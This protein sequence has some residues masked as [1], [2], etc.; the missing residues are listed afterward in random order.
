MKANISDESFFEPTL[1]PTNTKNRG[2]MYIDD[3]IYDQLNPSESMQ[4]FLEFIRQFSCKL[5]TP[6][7]DTTDDSFFGLYM[8]K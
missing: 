3:V 1:T 5:G 8:P 7:H 2:Y 6:A 4:D